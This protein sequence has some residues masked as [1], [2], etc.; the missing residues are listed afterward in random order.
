MRHRPGVLH[1]AI[2]HDPAPC[3]GSHAFRPLPIPGEGH[4]AVPKTR[5]LNNK[6]VAPARH[7]DS[8]LCVL[9]LVD[10]V[11]QGQERPGYSNQAGDS[12]EHGN[13][14]ALC[15]PKLAD[16]AEDRRIRRQP[17]EPETG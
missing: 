5:L 15:L 14:G 4:E 8:G 6:Q 7:I 13:Q 11:Q 10:A 16:L 1:E 3:E 17:I 9:P 12:E 2:L